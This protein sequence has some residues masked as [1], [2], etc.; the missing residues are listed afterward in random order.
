MLARR[1]VLLGDGTLALIALWFGARA[2]FD[3]APSATMAPSLEPEEEHVDVAVETERLPPVPAHRHERQAALGFSVRSSGGV[4]GAVERVQQAV[5]G[6]RVLPRA[7]HARSAP[8][9]GLFEPGTVRLEI[10]T[11]GGAEGGREAAEV[12]RG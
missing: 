3:A 6:A 2:W 8:A 10:A 1:I 5:D 12:Q 4:C 9:H 7:F 11:A